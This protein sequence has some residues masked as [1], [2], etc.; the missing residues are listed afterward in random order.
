MHLLQLGQGQVAGGT[1]LLDDAPGLG[2][3]LLHHL[4]ALLLQLLTVFPCLGGGLLHLQLQAAG[5][6]PLFLHLLALLVQTGEHVLKAH[7]LRVQPGG[8]LV[9]D[10]L[11]QAQTAGD[12]KGVGLAR[13]A[14]HQ[15]IGGGQGVHVELAGGVLH[16]GGGHGVY[17][18]LGIVGGGAHLGTHAPHRFDDGGGQGRALHR[19][20]ARPQLVEEDQALV[21]RLL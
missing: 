12:G 19:V 10:V 16:P 18:Q 15:A 2:L 14:Q 7:V 4:G 20:G 11:R 1:G 5:L 8:G 13:D 9:D 3:G 21:V 17:L 6:R